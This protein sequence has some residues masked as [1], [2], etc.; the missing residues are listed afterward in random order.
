MFADSP[1]EGYIIRCGKLIYKVKPDYKDLNKLQID[2]RPFDFLNCDELD[3]GCALDN[4]LNFE[5][6]LRYCRK[7]YVSNKSEET[8]LF[9]KLYNMYRKRFNFNHKDY[10]RLFGLYCKN[11]L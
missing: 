5:D 6:I 10:Q 3:K 8:L 4:K 11:L 9:N 7:K 1:L 2:S